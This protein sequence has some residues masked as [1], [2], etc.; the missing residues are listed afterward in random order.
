MIAPE[1]REGTTRTDFAE[2]RLEALGR[3]LFAPTGSNGVSARTALFER[4][5][6]SLD[7][8]ITQRR[9]A[10]TEVLRFPPVMTPPP[11][12]D[13]GLPPQ[14]SASSRLCL[15]PAGRRGGNPRRSRE[16]QCR[17]GLDRRV[18]RDRSCADACGLLSALSACCGARRSAG[19]R[20]RVRRRILL[21]PP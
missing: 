3:A 17:P 4:I 15:R 2:D 18:D 6:E 8:F 16:V 20:T 1:T 21:L 10:D 14:F 9:E 19:R 11:R 13:G 7:A 5:I 12:G